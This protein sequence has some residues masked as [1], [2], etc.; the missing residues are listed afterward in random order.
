MEDRM[1]TD[2]KTIMIVEDEESMRLLI[3]SLLENEY[4]IVPMCDGHDA[5]DYLAKNN[6]P[7]LII[8]DMEMPRVNGRVFVRRV[9]YS[10]K[11]NRIPIIVVSVIDKKMIINSFLKMGVLDYI[12]KPFKPE[13]LV[14]KVNEI[15]PLE[16][17]NTL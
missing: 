15:L 13:R 8:L 3:A 1:V 9:K 2:K 7:D 14:A 12:T 4:N 16:N 17:I 6:F 10:Y 5:L 11:H